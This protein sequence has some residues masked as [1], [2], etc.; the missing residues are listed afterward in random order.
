MNLQYKLIT[1][2]VSAIMISTAAYGYFYLTQPQDII[3]IPDNDLPIANNQTEIDFSIFE[4]A[5]NNFSLNFYNQLLD[6]NEKNIFFSPYSLFIAMAM[7]YEGA[8]GTTVENMQDVLGIPQNNE[9][10]LNNIKKIYDLLNQNVDYDVNTANALWI[11]EKFELLDDYQNIITEYYGGSATDVDYTNP[12]DAASIINQWVE[13]QTNGKIKDLIKAG[14]INPVLT[15]L[16]LTNAIYFKGQWEIQFD[17]A[18]TTDREFNLK[19][20]QIVQVPTMSIVES[21]NYFNYT[22]T[23]DLKI[24]ELPYEGDDLSMIIILPHEKEISEIASSMTLSDLSLW[25]QSL[26][27][28]HVDIYLPKF[29]FETDYVCND[30]LINLGMDNPFTG[31]ADFSKMSKEVQLY[32]SKVIHKA[33]IDVN[34]EGT[35]AAAA[36]A[37]IMYKTSF[38]G[39]DE[40]DRY[41]FNADHPFI[42]IIQHKQTGAVLFMGS[43]DSPSYE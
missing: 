3:E 21:D 16:I 40:Q 43:V 15:Y 20:G 28:E 17:E 36:T 29:K 18:N 4:G 19:D 23:D 35:E 37:V 26:K 22:E 11:R 6:D 32:I 1:V 24:L 38:P 27:P 10:I 5:L 12:E 25:R 34:E 14:D 2:I 33:F 30:Y 13:E 9:T 41:T 8:N 39:D 31:A 42:Y 7:T